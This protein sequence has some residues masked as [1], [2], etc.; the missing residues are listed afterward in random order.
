MSDRPSFPTKKSAKE[1]GYLTREKWLKL[2]ETGEHRRPHA[3]LRDAHPILVKGEEFF[4]HSD[5]EPLIS[6]TEAKGRGLSV[7]P[8]AEPLTFPYT[9][10]GVRGRKR[11]PVYRLSDCIAAVKRSRRR[12]PAAEIDLLLAIFTANRSAKRF[13]DAASSHYSCGRYGMAGFTSRTKAKL[14][15]LKDRGLIAAVKS[16][17]LELVGFHASLAVYRGDG[18]CFHSLLV[19]KGQAPAGA[20][21]FGGEGAIWVPATPKGRGEAR[22]KDA[23]HTLAKLP[24]SEIG[25]ERLS[26][27]GLRNYRSL[28]FE[29]V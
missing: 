21:T 10:W 1:A 16:G 26:G 11:Y 28:H 18:Y 8:D 29:D 17:R 9:P 22:L 20:D 13:R 19:P 5:C 23:V 24:C 4:H 15:D 27:A 6:K 14:Y 3:P 12:I 7:P 2:R 25:F